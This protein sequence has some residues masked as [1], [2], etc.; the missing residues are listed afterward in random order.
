MI[1]WYNIEKV[2]KGIKSALI[3][4]KEVIPWKTLMTLCSCWMIA[5]CLRGT[6]RDT[7]AVT[8][9]QKMNLHTRSWRLCGRM[10]WWQTSTS[11]LCSTLLWR[12]CIR[13]GR[14]MVSIVNPASSV[15]WVTSPAFLVKLV[16]QLWWCNTLHK[17]KRQV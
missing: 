14:S 2:D 9:Q 1:L 11:P 10:N 8:H 16:R 17:Y 4:K 6:S 7:L 12:T 13:C 15:S 5:L 3:H